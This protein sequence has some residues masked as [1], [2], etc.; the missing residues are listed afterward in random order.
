M[1]INNS[2]FPCA[3]YYADIPN[4]PCFSGGE[5]LFPHRFGRFECRCG[6]TVFGEWNYQAP[7]TG[8]NVEQRVARNEEFGESFN[9][10]IRVRFA[11]I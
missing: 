2:V 7:T 5:K 8:S 6:S 3:G 10:V 4:V 11:F 9:G 1:R